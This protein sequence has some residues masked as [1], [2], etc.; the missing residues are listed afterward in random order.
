MAALIDNLLDN[1]IKYSPPD[2]RVEVRIEAATAEQPASLRV[3]DEGPGIPPELHRQVFRRFYRMPG[4]DQAGSGLGLA[5]VEAP[6]PAT[7][8]GCGWSPAWA[9]AAWR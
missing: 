4:Q 9:A 8:P 6:P 7:R 2:S 1:A 5:I 3:A